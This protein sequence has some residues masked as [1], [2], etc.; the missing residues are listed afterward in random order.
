MKKFNIVVMSLLVVIAGVYNNIHAMDYYAYNSYGY[1]TINKKEVRYL[2]S[3]NQDKTLD[4]IASISEYSYDILYEVY[5]EDG[6]ALVKAVCKTCEK[7]S[8]DNITAWEDFMKMIIDKLPNNY[9]PVNE[10]DITN[11]LKKIGELKYA[12]LPKNAD[13]L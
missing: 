11:I 1:K 5:K 4:E 7:N 8:Y 3:K 13:L 12:D 6:N 10:V 2:L 9:G